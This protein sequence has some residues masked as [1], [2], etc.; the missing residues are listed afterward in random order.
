MKFN[1]KIFFVLSIVL[2]TSSFSQ[3]VCKSLLFLSSKGISQKNDSAIIIENIRRSIWRDSIVVR[4]ANN[5]KKIY[6]NKNVWGYQEYERIDGCVI[7]R[8]YNYE[9]YEVR[10]MDS[11]IIYS[12]EE[13]FLNTIITTYYFSK[14]LDSQI[15]TLRWKNIKEQFKDNFCFLE[16]LEKN[17]KHYQDYSKIDKENGNYKFIE[18]YDMCK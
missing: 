5:S 3:K 8:N 15:Y 1:K 13:E 18:F 16:R 4:M 11:L 9:F 6:P 17:F 2:A 7:Y 10:Q 12:I 14:N